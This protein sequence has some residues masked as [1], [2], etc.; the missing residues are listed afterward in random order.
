MVISETHLSVLLAAAMLTA[1]GSGED[2]GAQRGGHGPMQ[3]SVQ[4]LQPRVLENIIRTTGSLLANEAIG[5][6]VKPRDVSP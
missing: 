3:V 6:V 1:C 2:S 4:V 5:Y